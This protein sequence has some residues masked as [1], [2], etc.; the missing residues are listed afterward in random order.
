MGGEPLKK[1]LK[2][3]MYI[4]REGTRRLESCKV[5]G[6]KAESWRQNNLTPKT[7]H[8]RGQLEPQA[9][10]HCSNVTIRRSLGISS[11]PPVQHAGPGDGGESE[12]L[13]F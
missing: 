1:G 12:A 9:Q 3:N 13:V 7:S 10:G 8:N 5:S 11:D 6:S 2:F 4:G